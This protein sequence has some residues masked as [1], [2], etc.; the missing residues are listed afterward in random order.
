METSLP[1]Y[2]P[3]VSYGLAT[4]PGPCQNYTLTLRVRIIL[5]HR[6]TKFSYLNYNLR[7]PNKL[8]K[9]TNRSER[10]TKSSHIWTTT[11]DCLINFPSLLT[12]SILF[13]CYLQRNQLLPLSDGTVGPSRCHIIHSKQAPLSCHHITLPAPSWFHIT[14]TKQAPCHAITSHSQHH[15]DFTSHTPSRPHCHAITTTCKKDSS[16]S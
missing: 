2:Y 14:H 15:H 11:W 9:F 12:N 7:L 13:Q 3:H 16:S 1:S 5:G 4:V 10:L 6:L 8:F